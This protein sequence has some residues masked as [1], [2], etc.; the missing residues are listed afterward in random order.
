MFNGNLSA[1]KLHEFV[2]IK[3]LT[4]Y[5]IH[6]ITNYLHINCGEYGKKILNPPQSAWHTAI[7]WQS[8]LT[9]LNAIDEIRVLTFDIHLIYSEYG[10]KHNLHQINKLVCLHLAYCLWN[11]DVL[12]LDMQLIGNQNSLR[13]CARPNWRYSCINARNTAF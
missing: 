1:T 6:I 9:W 11:S 2:T 10:F 12:E 13:T 4:S 8:M 7:L 5:E 3:I